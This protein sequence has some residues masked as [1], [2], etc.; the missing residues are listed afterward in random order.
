VIYLLFDRLSL[1][2][3]RKPTTPLL[4]APDPAIG[5]QP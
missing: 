5:N 1:R 4:P 3:R 2:F